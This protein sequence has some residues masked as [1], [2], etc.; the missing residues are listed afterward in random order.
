VDS[1]FGSVGGVVSTTAGYAGGE[2]PDPTYHSL[3]DHTETVEV[4]YD[5]SRVSFRDLL[6]VFWES[7]DPTEQAWSR[8]Y[9]NAVFYHSEEQQR[10]ALETRSEVEGRLGRAVKTDVEPAGRF[11][12]AEDYHQKYTLRRY[13]ELWSE[14]RARF[15]SED[16]A[17]ASTAAAR[18]NAYLAGYGAPSPRDVEALG[19]SPR[20]RERLRAAVR[21]V[22]E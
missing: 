10:L 20:G 1:R 9:R 15:A 14:V 7:H 13:P 22:A 4:E 17:V 8:Q 21:R 2:K 19:L 16:A 5:P 11:Y 12:A 6:R 3:G 18:L